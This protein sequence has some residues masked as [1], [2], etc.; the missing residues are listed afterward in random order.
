MQ[1]YRLHSRNNFGVAIAGEFSNAINDCGTYVRG[2]A[3]GP[4]Y[5]GDCSTFLDASTWSDNMKN[6]FLNFQLASM[7]A[8]GDWF[9]WTWKVRQHLPHTRT[10]AHRA[11]R[12]ATTRP[13]TLYA[14]L[15]GHTSLALRVVGS[16]RTRARHSAPAPSSASAALSSAAPSSRGKLA[17]QA[18]VPLRPRRLY[19]SAHSPR[20]RSSVCP[21]AKCRSS[22][23]TRLR[24]RP[25]RSQRQP[26]RQRPASLHRSET[27]GQTRKILHSSS[28]P[29]LGA[30]I[31]TPGMRVTRPSLPARAAPPPVWAVPSLYL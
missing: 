18:R 7:D 16:R 15:C 22:T 11:T 23:R 3:N 17:V 27:D 20:R 26:S 12:L 2:V 24:A 28:P 9:F 30:R 10:D 13:P 25:S 4:S 14:P 19:S 31:P 6:G 8:L 29:S 1:A 21:T 5:G